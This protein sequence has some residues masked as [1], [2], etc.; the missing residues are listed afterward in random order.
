MDRRTFLKKMLG[1]G[2]S[3]IGLSS[4]TYYYAREMEPSMLNVQTKTI[5]STK[6]PKTFNNFKII[7]F[8]DTHIGFHYTLEQFRQLVSK[9]NEYKPDLIVFTGDLVDNPKKYVWN[10]TIIEQLRSLSATQGKFWVYGNHDH[11]G[12][13]T[14]VVKRVMDRAN[15]Q[16]LKNE[17]TTIDLNNDRIV[18]AGVDD[19]ILGKPNLTTALKNA[20]PD[21][22]TILLAHEPDFVEETIHFP[23]D[24]QL[25]GH[26]HGGQ[27]R[28]PFIGHL[29][30]PRYAEKYVQGKYTFKNGALTLHV[31]NGIGTTRLPYRFLCKPEIH[32]FTLKS[33]RASG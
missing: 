7:H 1:G 26:S 6:L 23:V 33:E 27:V 32:V 15:F 16:L 4:G 13:G 25:S 20:N 28:F 11:G 24:V 18:I 5:S 17:H 2:L 21:L 10:D 31:S 12:Y 3:I 30:T 22:F 29:Y 8:T 19:A 14:D 9:I